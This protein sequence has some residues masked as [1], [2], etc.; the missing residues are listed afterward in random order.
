MITAVVDTNVL[1]SGLGWPRGGP[2]R[3]VDAMIAGRFL[4][5]TS[6]AL[7]DELSRVLSYPKLAK[8]FDDADRLVELVRAISVV[9]EPARTLHVV[10]DDADNRVLEAATTAQVDVVVTGDAG[11][12]VVGTYDGVRMVTARAFLALLR[13]ETG[14]G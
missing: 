3:V 7:L 9:V 6:P 4:L 5:V 11:L 8:V 1:V 14:E 2:G 13:E 10:A 12:L